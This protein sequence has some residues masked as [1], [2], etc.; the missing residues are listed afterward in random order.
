MSS[1]VSVSAEAVDMY[2]KFRTAKKY[3]YLIFKFDDKYKSVVVDKMAEEGATH[4]D[5]LRDVPKNRV[6]YI[7][8]DVDYSLGADGNRRETLLISFSDDN[9]APGKEKMLISGTLNEVKAKCKEFK[10]NTSINDYDELTEA[11][12]LSIIQSK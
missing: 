2:N 9:H 8:Y 3:R 1:G 12:I 6:S 11:N 7:F 10:K 5:F 4:E